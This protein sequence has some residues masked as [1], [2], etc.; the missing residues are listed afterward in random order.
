MPINYTRRHLLLTLLAL[1]WLAYATPGRTIKDATGR[2]ITVPDTIAKV[3]A[4]GPPAMILLYTLAPDKL[5]G[6]SRP[7]RARERAFIAEPYR[8]LPALGRLAGRGNTANLE[9]VL[10]LKP[11]LILDYGSVAPTFVSLAERLQAQ[12]G[13]PTLLLDGKMTLIPQT[14]R[15]LG[16]IFGVPARGEKLAERSQ[17]FIDEAVQRA[18]AIPEE[19]RPR[20]YYA[21][22]SDGLNTAAPGSINL[23]ALEFLKVRN[24]AGEREGENIYR[25]SLEQVLTWNPEVI[26]TIDPV[27]YGT[28]RD[29]PRW[30]S[31]AAVQA[32]RIHLAPGQPFGWVDFPPSVNRLLGIYWLGKMLYPEQFPE[33]LEARV[34]DFFKTFYHLSLT[35][36]QVAELLNP[37]AP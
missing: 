12:T 13:I 25:V 8:D 36:I 3:F 11:D 35:D 27:F 30:Q 20:V 19:G 23:E 2:S 18:R 29:D 4:A 6:W 28:V 7:L 37:A 15:R 10:A 1:P 24:V 34:K 26:I 33:P 17:A 5:T 31:V 9:T 16:T 22:D 14:Y 32:G 21:R